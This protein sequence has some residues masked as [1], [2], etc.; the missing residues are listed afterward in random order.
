[1]KFLCLIQAVISIFAASLLAEQEMLRPSWHQYNPD[2][3]TETWRLTEEKEIVWQ[4]DTS[5][6]RISS[7]DWIGTTEYTYDEN[8]KLA[9]TTTPSGATTLYTYYPLGDLST[10]TYPSGKVIRYTYLPGGNLS[11]VVFS[12]IVISHV[13]DTKKNLLTKRIFGNG[14][15]TT[16]EYD[17]ARLVSDI[18]HNKGTKLIAHFHFEYDL[19]GNQVLAKKTTPTEE[20]TTRYVYDRLYRLKEAY[21][22]KGF[23]EKYTYDSLGNRRTKETPKGI[24]EYKYDQDRL[25]EVGNTTYH[26]DAAGF[27]KQKKTSSEDEVNYTY[28]ELGQLAQYDDNRHSVIFTYNGRGERIS[29]EVNSRHTDYRYEDVFPRSQILEEK[30]DQKTREYVYGKHCLGYIEGGKAFYYLEDSP[31]NSIGFII[32]DYGNIV[33]ELEYDAF[34]SCLSSSKSTLQYN[35]EQADFETGLI[36]LRT[37]YYDPQIGRF[38]SPD[39]VPGNFYNPQS[40][41]RYAYVH[42]NPRNLQD[43]MGTFVDMPDSFEP[44]AWSVGVPIHEE[45]DPTP[46]EGMTK[47]CISARSRGFIQHNPSKKNILRESNEVEGHAWLEIITSNDTH[48]S[49]SIYGRQDDKLNYT[50]ITDVSDF[51]Y[52]P[53]TIRVAVLV[54]DDMAEKV[55]TSAL[56]FGETKYHLLAHNCVQCTQEGAEVAG[57]DFLFTA[58]VYV[59]PARTGRSYIKGKAIRPTTLYHN[60]QEVIVK[61]LNEV[62]ITKDMTEDQVKFY[63][64]LRTDSFLKAVSGGPRLVLQGQR[65][66]FGGISLSKQAELKL[67]LKEIYGVVFDEATQQ[68]ILVGERD[69]RL[70]EMR[71]DDLAVAVQSVYGLKG[72]MQDP[73][74]S[75]EPFKDHMNV[76][77]KGA[78][79]GTEFGKTLFEG[80]YALKMLFL[81][82]FPC[83][84]PGFLS[85][86]ERRKNYH[87][88]SHKNRIREN[89]NWTWRTWIEPD[90]IILGQSADCSTMIFETVKMRC[91]A[92]TTYHGNPI[93]YPPHRDFANYFTEN[94]DLIA[95]QYPV[96]SEVKR[97]GQITGIVKW[98]KNSN[99][100]FDLNFFQSYQPTLCKTP[101]AI[102]KEKV[103]E[104]WEK[105]G[106]GGL[107]GGIQF[108][109][110]SQNFSIR[111]MEGLTSLKTKVLESRPEET[112]FSWKVEGFNGSSLVAEVFPLFKTRKTGCYSQTF[113][114]IQYPVPGNFALKL[115][116][117]YNSFNDQDRGFGVGWTAIPFELMLTNRVGLLFGETTIKAP[118]NIISREE[119]DEWIYKAHSYEPNGRVVYMRE[120]GKQRLYKNPD[121]TYCLELTGKGSI[122]FDQKGMLIRMTDLNALSIEYH[123]EE[124]KLLS[125]TH[126]NGKNIRLEYEGNKIKEAIDP[127]GNR[128]FYEY[129]NRKQLAEV[130]NSASNLLIAYKYDADLRLSEITSPKGDVLFE[131]SYDDYNRLTTLQIGKESLRKEYNLA[132]KTSTTTASNG[133]YLEDKYDSNYSLIGQG[134]QGQNLWNAESLEN[135][136]IK[137]SFPVKDD[138]GW[139]YVYDDIGLLKVATDPLN[140]TWTFLYDENN[141]LSTEHNPSGDKTVFIYDEQNHLIEKITHAKPALTISASHNLSWQFS[142]SNGFSTRYKYNEMGRLFRIEQGPNITTLSYDENGLAKEI[143]FPS[144]Y[145]LHREL[146]ENFRLKSLFDASGFLES[147]TYT[148]QGLVEKRTTSK[149]SIQYTYEEGKISSITDRHGYKT[150]FT[151]VH[152]NLR[153]VKDAE[154]CFTAYK[155]RKLSNGKVRIDILNPFH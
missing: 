140:R 104:P 4:Y 73:G 26:Y 60:I 130:Y 129:D 122:F 143:L 79:Y 13:Y 11:T 40:L 86:S 65:G 45:G 98:L 10:I 21:N 113:I 114:D 33:E 14:M 32:N 18:I 138:E 83:H 57:L 89:Q 41:N 39:Q 94:Y 71:L 106:R 35:R 9:S 93:D 141:N 1:M 142:S 135:N 16:Y 28:N 23:F 134:V 82:K 53:D 117:Y 77:Y 59:G 25:I 5:G 132:K 136:L 27:L 12:S 127:Q 118:L 149:G 76:S 72:E 124:G 87:E 54:S 3:Q 100:P 31:S 75:I 68:L 34:G 22:S 125:I 67:N 15:T 74:I 6:N 17:E 101:L 42:N 49:F 110:D 147:F 102:P 123:I 99:L 148:D 91:L 116:R 131:G 63:N 8:H 47:L 144:G 51:K 96:F 97:L 2:A 126:Q 61:K 48:K 30:K 105:K 64:F 152:G 43:P 155:P 55:I 154:G 145:T 95:E 120:D 90:E 146:D 69:F 36:F 150:E 70:P 109:L 37:R 133:L 46:P 81:G 38:I 80:D 56:K 20:V 78:T 58:P 19:M 85:F 103:G 119:E 29:K 115:S 139:S 50:C 121:D 128:L 24:V 112:D 137:A 111:N 62:P 66:T 107:I 153:G 52:D 92:E 151:Y 108:V 84:I 44:L 88:S 7:K